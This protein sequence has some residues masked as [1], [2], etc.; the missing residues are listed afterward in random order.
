MR[1]ITGKARGVKLSALE[2]E[3]ITRPTGDRVKEGLFSAIQFELGESAC[4][5]SSREADSWHWRR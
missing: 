5:I 1:I 3:D 2:G 4:W